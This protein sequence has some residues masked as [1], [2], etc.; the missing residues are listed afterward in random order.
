MPQVPMPGST[1]N[2]NNGNNSNSSNSNSSNSSSLAWEQECHR[3][4]REES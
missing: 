1:G 3:Q 2:D 4:A